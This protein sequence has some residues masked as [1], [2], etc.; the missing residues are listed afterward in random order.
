MLEFLNEFA[1]EATSDADETSELLRGRLEPMGL[2]AFDP[3][4]AIDTNGFV[5]TG[6]TASSVGL[7]SLSDLADKG[8]DLILGGVP[9]CPTNAFCLP[10]LKTVYGLDLSAGFVPLDGGGPLTIAA[11]ESGDIDVAI[12]FSTNGTIADKG[13]VL[14]EDDKVMLAADNVIPVTTAEVA[15]AYGDELREL[16]DRVSAA[17]ST[18][19]LTE[20][21][22]RFD[23]DHDDADAIAADWLT[24]EGLIGG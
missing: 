8:A 6:E 18:E 9:D 1:G 7:A 2:V 16:V 11:L 20:L 15:D 12:L 14:L 3:S 4:P 17:M 5:V 23:I 10:G 21:N 19:E 22:R 13:W 24:T